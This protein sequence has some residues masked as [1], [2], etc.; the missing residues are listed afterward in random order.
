[1]HS[2]KDIPSMKRIKRL[3]HVPNGIR[4]S[5]ISRN[6]KFIIFWKWRMRSLNLIPIFTPKNTIVSI[7]PMEIS[8]IFL[9]HL[10]TMRF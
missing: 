8:E 9:Q 2:E 6:P 7:S 10:R 4:N 1:M 3:K 5:Q